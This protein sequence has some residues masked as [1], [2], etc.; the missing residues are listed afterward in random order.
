MHFGGTS[1]T[2]RPVRMNEAMTCRDVG[3]VFEAGIDGSLLPE[4]RRA[5][6]A[7]L[8]GCHACARAFRAAGY[9]RRLLRR[10]PREP[11]PDPRK[12]ALLAALRSART[13]PSSPVSRPHP[14]QR[15]HS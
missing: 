1:P 13:C 3:D 8:D 5:L 12:T 11:M 6:G 7:H 15:Y 9:V 14:L 2:M 4:R 10:M